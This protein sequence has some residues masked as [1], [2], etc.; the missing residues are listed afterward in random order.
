MILHVNTPKRI[1]RIEFYIGT[2]KLVAKRG[3][4][5]R[6]QV[7]AILVKDN[8]I[9]ASGY[10]GAPSGS[11]PC[12]DKLT[13]DPNKP[14]TRAIH[15]EAN[16][17]AFCAKNGIATEGCTLYTSTSPCIK[18]A[19]LIIQSGIQCVFYLEEYRDM[20]GLELLS[21]YHIPHKLIN[22]SGI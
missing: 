5:I 10:N 13:C 22:D 20:A 18:C 14:C 3:S 12:P 2:L 9:I 16:L 4:C 15:A 11:P 8:R 21:M 19:E 7:G 17:I 1:S 6:N